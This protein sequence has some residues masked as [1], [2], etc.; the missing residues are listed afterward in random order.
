MR[1]QHVTVH[2]YDR[3][4]HYVGHSAKRNW[5]IFRKWTMSTAKRIHQDKRP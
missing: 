2:S 4:L 5:T 3:Y 1:V